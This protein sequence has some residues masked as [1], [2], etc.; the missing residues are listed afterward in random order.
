MKCLFEFSFLKIRIDSNV[1]DAHLNVEA[2]HDELLRY[3]RSVSSSRWLMLKIF[4]VVI[5]FVII[6]AIFLA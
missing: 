4:G 1:D 2:A 3:F 5:V 6:F